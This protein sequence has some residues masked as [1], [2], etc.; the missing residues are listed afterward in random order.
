M[1]GN[2][3][4][5]G[6]RVWRQTIV[7]GLTGLLVGSLS[8]CVL[9]VWSHRY[10]PVI[11]HQERSVE[12]AAVLNGHLDLYVDLDRVRDCPSETS[13]WLWTWVDYNGQRLKQFYPLF[14][15]SAAISTLGRD[16]R[17]I[18]SIPLP[19][20]LWAGDWYYWSKTV[21]RCPFPSS[22][23]RNPILESSDIPIHILSVA[24]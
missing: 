2:I 1:M 9:I 14:N 19:P 8:G 11:M 23:F 16:Q 4:R 15:T 17:F 12:E 10:P 7:A 3:T 5:V 13:R 6:L 22:L 24:P 20:G 21:E 18:I